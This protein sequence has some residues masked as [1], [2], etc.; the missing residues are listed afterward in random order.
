MSDQMSYRFFKLLLAMPLIVIFGSSI[1]FAESSEHYAIPAD[2][3]DLFWCLPFAFLLLSIGLFPLLRERLWHHHYGKITF[4]WALIFLIPS[5]F[6]FSFTTTLH[7]MSHVMIVDYLPFIILLFALFT[8]SGGI[9]LNGNI[10][11]TPFVNTSLMAVGTVFSSIMGT[12]GASMLLIRPFIQANQ[13]RRHRV[14]IILFFIFLVANIGGSLTP[15]GDPPLFLG[16]LHGIDFFWPTFNLFKPMIFMSG[17]LLVLFFIVDFLFFRFEDDH[18]KKQDFHSGFSINGKINFVFLTGIIALLFISGVWETETS[19]HF[20]GQDVTLSKIITNLGMIIV[21][22]LSLIFTPKIV[23]ESNNFD[24]EPFLEVA[25]IFASIFITIIPVII[26][27]KSGED[28]ALGFLLK[29]VNQD[30]LPVPALYFWITG[31]LSSFL[32]NAPTYLVF[33]NATGALPE[34]LM[35]TFSQTLIAISTG[36]VFMG[37]MTYIGNAPNFMVRSIAEHSGIKMPSFFGYMIYSCL[38]LLPLLFV[39]TYL[40]F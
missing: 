23:R 13:Y 14:H 40:F 20:L 15:L 9:Q 38:I 7:A 18:P 1:A 11:G 30:G 2:Q 16:F 32:D 26:I 10:I 25:K 33:F 36:A 29:A 3:L 24:W 6:I 19:Y 39:M 12:T 27:L 4:F 17:V 34:E 31:G 22:C 35:T 8:I 28:S 5:I 21:T 37:A